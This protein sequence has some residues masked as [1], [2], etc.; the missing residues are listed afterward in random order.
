MP[1]LSSF[2]LSTLLGVLRKGSRRLRPRIGLPYS[3]RSCLCVGCH[4]HSHGDRL[5]MRSSGS[6]LSA[7]PVASP[8]SKPCHTGNTIFLN[9]WSHSWWVLSIPSV[10]PSHVL[11][12]TLVAH[13]PGASIH[14][15]T[16]PPHPRP[17]LSVSFYRLLFL[18]S[19]D[20]G[21]SCILAL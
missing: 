15:Q 5:V 8:Y 1:W 19:R 10:F 4:P 16:I 7:S 18:T 2:S 17:T 21:L 20:P 12:H 14:W 13:L 9:W 3:C 11:S 6:F